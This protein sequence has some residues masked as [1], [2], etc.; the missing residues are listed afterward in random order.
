MRLLLDESVPRPLRTS[1]PAAYEVRT[2]P[3]MG[4]AGTGNGA[5]LRLAADDGFDAL[6]TVD[7]GFA[8]Q[9]NLDDLPL[10]VVV[11]LAATNRPE[12]LRP[13]VPRVIDIVS[14]NLQRR[15]YHVSAAH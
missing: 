3:E 1:F 10:P 15:V 11:V 5:L 8:H 6:L 9:Q 4:W 2:V 12:E 14:G 13:L 7:R